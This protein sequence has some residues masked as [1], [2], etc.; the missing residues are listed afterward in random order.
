MPS[1]SYTAH[2]HLTPPI[3]PA[4][5]APPPTESGKSISS[6]L[7]NLS[8]NNFVGSAP[9]AGYTQQGFPSHNS[10]PLTAVVPVQSPLH[11]HYPRMSSPIDDEWLAPAS[12]HN[13]LSNS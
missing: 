12:T 3:A 7:E 4:A 9:L 1:P 11:P 13:R 5:M 2:S 10:L 6:T 8:A